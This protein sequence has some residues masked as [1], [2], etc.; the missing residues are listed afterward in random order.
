MSDEQTPFRVELSEREIQAREQFVREY[1]VDEDIYAAALRCGCPASNAADYGK[2]MYHDPY[3]QKRKAEL[4]L[5]VPDHTDVDSEV[6]KR[7][8]IA[9]LLREANYHGPGS[10]HAARVSA[11]ANLTNVFGLKA[12]TKLQSEVTHRGKVMMVPAI[13]NIEEWEAQAQEHQDGLLRDVAE[14]L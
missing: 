2:L 8:V 1:L 13:A 6:N 12:P 14:A 3:V 5:D 11:L 4:E 10:S 7:K 9:A